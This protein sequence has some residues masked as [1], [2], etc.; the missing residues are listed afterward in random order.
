[1]D[2]CSYAEQFWHFYLTEEWNEKAAAFL[3]TLDEDIVVIGTGKHEF[4]ESLAV[5]QKAL[6]NEK[7]ERSEIHFTIEP[8]SSKEKKCSEDVR[9]VYGTLHAVGLVDDASAIVDMDCRYSVIFQKNP[10]GKWKI[11][12]VH[13]SLPNWE[14]HDGE[15]YPKTLVGQVKEAEDRAQQMERLAKMDQLTEILNH[16]SFF[17]EC[18]KMAGGDGAFCCM[19]I[20]LD[21]FKQIKDIHGHLEGNRVLRETGQI[22]KEIS[23]GRGLA[24]RVGG[25]E[26]ALFFTDLASAEEAGT[27]AEA[28]LEQARKRREE[29]P[30]PGL[31]IGI[32]RMGKGERVRDTFRRADQML[33][34]VK[35]G[36]KHAYQIN[37]ENLV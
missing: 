9:L 20:D 14:Q 29:M 25:D 35:R 18:G 4:Y 8:V 22:L 6:Q 21:N 30:F 19:A 28:I 33:Y 11:I 23:R 1:M 26:F 13:Q 7:K 15:F 10:E 17:D 34:Q 5:F 12:H 32:A 36:G 2:L 24:G 37:P 31:S 16:Q 27:I 3:Q